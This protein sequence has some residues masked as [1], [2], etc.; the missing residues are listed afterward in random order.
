MPLTLGI[1]N[2]HDFKNK[3]LSLASKKKKAEKSQRSKK[4]KKKSNL[5]KKNTKQQTHWCSYT[6]VNVQK[7]FRLA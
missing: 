2:M 6:N 4:K 5:T 1:W 3:R 7:K